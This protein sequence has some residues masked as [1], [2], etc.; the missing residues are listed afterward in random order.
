MRR[1]ILFLIFVPWAALAEQKP[2]VLPLGELSGHEVGIALPSEKIMILIAFSLQIIWALLG[3]IF[4]Q[5]EKSNNKSEEKL[6]RLYDMVHAM[7][8]DLKKLKAAPSEDEMIVRIQPYI[9]LGVL[10]EFK[11]YEGRKS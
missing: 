5:K 11:K 4:K 1:W 10:R 8:G 2:I 7:Q 6:D 3:Y 9:E